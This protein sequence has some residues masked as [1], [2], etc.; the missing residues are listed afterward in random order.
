[1]LTAHA[2]MDIQLKKAY[3]KILDSLSQ[4][5]EQYQ[6]IGFSLPLV[7]QNVYNNFTHRRHAMKTH[8]AFIKAMSAIN[9][10]SWLYEDTLFL[11]GRNSLT[12]LAQ[13]IAEYLNE[14]ENQTEYAKKIILN[15]DNIK[16]ISEISEINST[17]RTAL[18]LFCHTINLAVSLIIH[19]TGLLAVMAGIANFSLATLPVI[20]ISLAAVIVGFLFAKVAIDSLEM[21]GRLTFGNQLDDLETYAQALAQQHGIDLSTENASD[22]DHPAE[23]VPV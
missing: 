11:H 5:N 12:G 20:A 6:V 9:D 21:Y 17:S 16:Y 2:G 23:P 14:N 22:L 1:M 3:E 13:S 7:K 4:E 8:Y 10:L 18:E 19:C 15:I